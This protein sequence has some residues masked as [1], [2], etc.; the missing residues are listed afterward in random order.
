MKSYKRQAG[1]TLVE[2]AIV[3]VIIGLLLGAILKGQELI[4]SSRTKNAINEVSSIKAAHYSY[5]DRYKRLPGDDTPVTGRGGTWATAA[6]GNGNGVI[7]ATAADT[8]TGNNEVST[9]FRQLRAAG[10]LTGNPADTGANALP[11]NAFGGL[12]GVVYA[13]VQGNPQPVLAVCQGNVPG[14]AAVAMDTQSDDG[15]PNGGTVRATQGANNAAPAGAAGAYN[16]GQV[17]TVC[18]AI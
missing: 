1:F 17:Y 14:K 4:D 8:F 18:T 2:I 3:L 16:E 13:N 11:R 7:N 15:R 6:N 5:I 10:F 9:Y 12:T